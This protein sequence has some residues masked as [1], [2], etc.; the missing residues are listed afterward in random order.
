[1][2]T[3]GQVS[4]VGTVSAVGSQWEQGP[5]QKHAS[6]LLEALAFGSTQKRSGLHVVQALQDW[7]G[8]QFC[9]VGREQALHCIDVLRPNVA[10]AVGLLA[11]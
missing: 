8:T 5:T 6:Q 11:E 3:Y 10:N 2:E 9:N 4:V 7:G 1:M